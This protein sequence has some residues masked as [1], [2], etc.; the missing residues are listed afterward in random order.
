MHLAY[1]LL[2]SNQGKR[3][4]YLLEATT[5]VEG[6]GEIIL[7]SS[8]YET[9]AWGLE[10]QADFLNQAV[11]LKTIHNPFEL[12]QKL[13]EIEEK[14]GRKRIQKWG[15]RN[16]DLD[17]LYFDEEIINT[18]K[19]QIPHP[20]LHLRRFTLLPLCGICPN[21]EHPILQKT[22]EELLAICPDALP[23]KKYE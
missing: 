5:A 13:L 4:L 23:V 9:A 11:L 7:I 3:E 17:I 10:D 16:I 1:I 15:A 8:V 18:E 14:M 20:Q 6:L 12:M 19:L 21:L 2:G 22:N